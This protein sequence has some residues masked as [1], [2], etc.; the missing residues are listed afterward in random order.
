M[1]GTFLLAAAGTAFLYS[2]LHYTPG[3]LEAFGKQGR[4]FIPMAPLLYFAFS[5]MIS[6]PS[7]WEKWGRYLSIAIFS[8]ILT[9]YSFGLYATYYTYCDSTF[10]TLGTCSQPVYKNLDLATT[11][12]VKLSSRETLTQGFLR[13]CNQFESV[14]VY[15]KSVPDSPQGNLR[16]SILDNSDHLLAAQFIPISSIQSGH[17]LKINVASTNYQLY[18]IKLETSG[19]LPG[20]TIAFATNEDSSYG[21]GML[22]VAGKD[23]ETDL[24]FQY[25]CPGR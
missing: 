16:Y 12:V 9:L 18:K 4:Y 22:T 10:Y 21:N 24:I 14:S 7:R 19:M 2:Y 6:I 1:A 25:T 13:T 8:V 5:G 23:M 17:F 3:D 11:P 15:V 20:K